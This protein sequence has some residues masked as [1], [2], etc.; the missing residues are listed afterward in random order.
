MEDYVSAQ[1]Y[2]ERALAV[3]TAATVDRIGFGWAPNNTVGFTNSEFKAQTAAILDRL[4]QAIRDSAATV[5]PADPGIGACGPAGQPTWCSTVV[6]GALFPTAWQ[7]FSTW[8]P[9]TV[10]FTSAPVAATAGA[11][12]GPLT[13]QL[14]T[15]TATSVAQVATPVVFSSSSTRGT[16]AT[17]PA[18]PWTPTL[19]VTIPVGAGTAGVYYEDTAAGSPTIT[20]AIPGQPGATQ[21]ETVAAGPIAKLAVTAPA[22]SVPEGGRLSISATGTDAFG[23]S[24]VVTPS[25][26]V[27]PAV[28]GSVRTL[29]GAA[30]FVA[31]QAAGRAR[32]DATSGGVSAYRIVHVTAL[33]PRIASVRSRLVGG[34]LVVTTKVVTGKKPAV[35]V[36]L[37]LRVRKGSSVVADVTGKTN[38]QGLY[39]WRSK[40]KLP[41]ARYLIKATLLRP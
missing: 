33:P 24:I 32:I 40:G 39:V 18:G 3:D 37:E 13:L 41:K 29:A 11:A 15:G 17:S 6:P 21:T 22:P 25:W 36:R 19:T 14:Q 35:G 5:D 28:L 20:A 4:G 10:A 16:F 27:T 31:G 8:T 30:T 34:Y 7:A 1:V 12:A 38:K 9:A 23:N 2:A 26:R